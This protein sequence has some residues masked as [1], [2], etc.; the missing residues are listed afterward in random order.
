MLRATMLGELG[1]PAR[2][3]GSVCSKRRWEKGVCRGL[4]CWGS[5]EECE[6]QNGGGGREVA[7]GQVLGELE[8]GESGLQKKVGDRWLSRARMLG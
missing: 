5:W 6:L 8:L 7:Q 1:D 3:C 2:V 4:G